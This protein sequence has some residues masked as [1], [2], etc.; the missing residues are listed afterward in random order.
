M[1]GLDNSI[2]IAGTGSCQVF[3]STTEALSTFLLIVDTV[4]TIAP[5]WLKGVS[6]NDGSYQY[7]ATVLFPIAG[8]IDRRDLKNDFYSHAHCGLSPKLD[9]H[10]GWLVYQG[11]SR[12]A[13]C[14]AQY[15]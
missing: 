9:S 8:L 11:I 2:N 14:N 10:A 12:C 3:D 13:A 7:D 15:G 5:R 1:I 4:V 6:A